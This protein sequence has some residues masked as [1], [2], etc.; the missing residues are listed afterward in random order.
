MLIIYKNLNEQKCTYVF[1]LSLKFAYIKKIN[2]VRNQR[3]TKISN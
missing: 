2:L 1:A 3:L